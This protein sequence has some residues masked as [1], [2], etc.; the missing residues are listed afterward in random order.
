MNG[1]GTEEGAVGDGG[2]D[3]HPTGRSG[4]GIGG[5]KPGGV[6]GRGCKGG[7]GGRCGGLGP[8]GGQGGEGGDRTGGGSRGGC[9]G[10]EGGGGE[11]A[12]ISTEATVGEVVLSIFTAAPNTASQPTGL[13]EVAASSVAAALA[14]SDEAKTRCASTTTDPAEMLSATSVA[15]RNCARKAASNAMES[16]VAIVPATWNLMVTMVV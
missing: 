13:A 4:S 10:G 5:G 3:G 8:N 1:G 9:G 2:K 12:G 6:C 14:K 15:C 7:D 11:G 16:K